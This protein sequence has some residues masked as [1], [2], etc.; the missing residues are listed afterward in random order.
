MRNKMMFSVEI[1][2][3]VLAF[4]HPHDQKAVVDVFPNLW[5]E[6]ELQ[7]RRFYQRYCLHRALRY[8]ALRVQV[9]PYV[10]VRV[11]CRIAKLGPSDNKPWSSLPTIKD[12][13]IA[14]P[15]N[16]TSRHVLSRTADTLCLCMVKGINVQSLHIN[17]GTKTCPG[18]KTYYR[19]KHISPKQERWHILH[20]PD[21][22]P[23]LYPGLPYVQMAFQ[24]L[25]MHCNPSGSITKVITF[26]QYLRSDKR[27]RLV[28]MYGVPWFSNRVT[29][30]LFRDVVPHFDFAPL[31]N[32]V[33]P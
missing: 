29:S 25:S 23:G 33:M 2:G 18:T 6:A 7:T 3:I 28:S 9:W 10:P 30:F 15:K 32:L 20:L 22:Y 11:M 24:S 16:P 31:E 8:L 14:I 12:Y 26:G 13:R 21:A 1:W 19:C 5:C 27:M 17:V 4:L